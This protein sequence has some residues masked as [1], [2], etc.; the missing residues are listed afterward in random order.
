MESAMLAPWTA[1]L[2]GYFVPNFTL[3]LTLWCFKLRGYTLS[4][5][6]VGYKNWIR[7]FLPMNVKQFHTASIIN[8]FSVGELLCARTKDRFFVIKPLNPQIPIYISSMTI[9]K[10]S[11]VSFWCWLWV[12][13]RFDLL[14]STVSPLGLT[15]NF[16]SNSQELKDNR[17]F[18]QRRP[19]QSYLSSW[20]ATLRLGV[21]DSPN[22]KPF[23][24]DNRIF[25]MSSMDIKK[26]V[27]TQF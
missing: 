5:V 7:I 6:F 27:I 26:I 25:T 22:W 17:A 4:R 12:Y 3:K 18:T 2:N 23:L 24:K 16:L 19:V 8:Q 11:F 20:S 9:L 13:A 21:L 14:V 1:K 15:L 10:S